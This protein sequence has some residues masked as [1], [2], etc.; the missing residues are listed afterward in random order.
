[1]N[2]SRWNEYYTSKIFT[3][4]EIKQLY[5]RGVLSHSGFSLRAIKVQTLI[6]KGPD[7]ATCP[8]KI[9]FFASQR[10]LSSE[11][12]NRHKGRLHLNGWYINK[13]GRAI[14]MTYDHIIAR[15]NGGV[16]TLENGQCMCQICNLQKGAK[17]IRERNPLKLL[18]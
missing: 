7:C 14:L 2:S 18:S 13:D 12:T 17:Q 4:P 1:M 9:H 11:H 3:Y 10:H 8:A 6:E 15:S 16:T 5:E